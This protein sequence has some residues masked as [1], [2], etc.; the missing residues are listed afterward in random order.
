MVGRHIFS[1]WKGCKG[2][3]SWHHPHSQ[4]KQKE[5][6]SQTTSPLPPQPTTL[7]LPT[8]NSSQHRIFSMK[9]RKVIK[10]TMLKT[11]WTM[12]KFLQQR[13]LQNFMWI[14][15]LV[16]DFLHPQS[17]PPLPHPT[18][19]NKV[20]AFACTGTFI[21]SLSHGW[22]CCARNGWEQHQDLGWT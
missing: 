1:S 7:A 6:K 16:N 3:S 10:Q 11:R 19:W 20:W 15:I 8:V 4:E 2:C 9:S 18:H 22:W 5:K 17:F 21:W 14:P 13:R 12:R